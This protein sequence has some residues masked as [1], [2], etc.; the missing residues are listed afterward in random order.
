MYIVLV[1]GPVNTV[2]IK[3]LRHVNVLENKNFIKKYDYYE[4]D[5]GDN[6]DFGIHTLFLNDEEFKNL[7]EEK[8]IAYLKIDKDDFN[9]KWKPTY[10]ANYGKS[11]LFHIRETEY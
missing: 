5:T 11:S 7:K 6:S 1:N 9:V 4:Y 3:F 10:G 8:I 2:K